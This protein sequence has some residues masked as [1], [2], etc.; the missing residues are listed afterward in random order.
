LSLEN[1]LTAN[2]TLGRLVRKGSGIIRARF[3][4]TLNRA[5]ISVNSGRIVLDDDIYEFLVRRYDNCIRYVDGKVGEVISW[6]R[7]NNLWDDTLVII[8][9]DHGEEL[10]EHGGV[11]HGHTLFE[12]VLHVPLILSGGVV[13]DACVTSPTQIGHCDILPT[14]LEASGISIPRSMRGRPVWDLLQKP[15]GVRTSYAEYVGKSRKMAC[16]TRWPWK[17]AVDCE[18]ESRVLHNLVEDPL[19]TRPLDTHAASVPQDLA[20]E[21]EE[22]MYSLDEGRPFVSPQDGADQEE[23]LDEQLREQ[24]EQLG[25]L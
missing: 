24:L 3:A 18:A 17:Y 13:E 22:F 8:T 25:Y 14:Q 11:G 21:L 2:T 4:W 19:E 7:E 20:S 16:V 10:G 5:I 1:N 12:E 15:G 23:D 9:G 6:M